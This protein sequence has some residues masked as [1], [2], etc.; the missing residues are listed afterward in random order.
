MSHSVVPE[1]FTTA[2]LTFGEQR[3]VPIGENN[4]LLNT[5]INPMEVMKT[6]RGEYEAILA[7]LRVSGAMKT[8]SPNQLVQEI[9]PRDKVQVYREIW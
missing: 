1:G 7:G 4:Q 8:T 9:T 6:A 5:V 2:I 3:I